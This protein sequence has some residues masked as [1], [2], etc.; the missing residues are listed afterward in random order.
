MTFIFDGILIIF[1]K[2]FSPAFTELNEYKSL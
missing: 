2:Y 1:L